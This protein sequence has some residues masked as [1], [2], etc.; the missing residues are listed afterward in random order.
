M[1][2]VSTD[3]RVVL[4]GDDLTVDRLLAV[5]RGGAHV[6][7]DAQALRRVRAARD[8][9]DRVLESGESV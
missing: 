5:A 4:S 3:E 2:V 8:V 1:A 7:L 6:G 9:V